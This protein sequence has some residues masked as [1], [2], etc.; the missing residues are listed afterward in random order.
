LTDEGKPMTEKKA[1]SIIK[2]ITEKL[3][4]TEQILI[5]KA[6]EEPNID[7]GG[8]EGEKIR[9]RRWKEIKQ[10]EMIRNAKYK[11]LMNI[12]EEKK[13][14]DTPKQIDWKEVELMWAKCDF[15]LNQFLTDRAYYFLEVL[16]VQDPNI[17]RAMFPFLVEPQVLRRVDEYVRMVSQKPVPQKQKITIQKLTRLYNMLKGRK[18]KIEYAEKG[19]KR[20]SIL[21]K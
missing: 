11:K 5:K 10:E 8:R 13:I 3:L 14:D 18:T 12:L 21:N 9:E 20:T 17:Y 16:R 1:K 19:G 6:G 15:L 7:L 4:T 2:G